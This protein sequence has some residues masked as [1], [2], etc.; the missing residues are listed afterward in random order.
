MFDR[1]YEYNNH[2]NYFILWPELNFIFEMIKMLVKTIGSL[3][4]LKAKKFLI[5]DF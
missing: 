4:T 1:N 3:F 5:D 2:L